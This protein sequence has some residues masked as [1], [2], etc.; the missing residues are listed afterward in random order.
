MSAIPTL[1]PVTVELK[2]SNGVP[3]LSGLMCEL[4]QVGNSRVTESGSQLQLTVAAR[5]EATARRRAEEATQGIVVEVGEPSLLKQFADKGA[6]PYRRSLVFGRKKPG[7]FNQQGG[8]G[9]HAVAAQ[10]Q[11]PT[12]ED[13]AALING[14]TSL[15][16]REKMTESFETWLSALDKILGRIV[17][18]SYLDLPDQN[19]YGWWSD[20]LSPKKA[21]LRAI[22]L[23]KQ[24]QEGQDVPPMLHDNPK[25][26]N[27]RQQQVAVKWFAKKTLRELRRRQ[28]LV[29]AQTK[30]AFS[31]GNTDALQNLNMMDAILRAA[32]DYKEFGESRSTPMKENTSVKGF[33]PEEETDTNLDSLLKNYPIAKDTHETLQKV[34]PNWFA[35]ERGRRTVVDAI[36]QVRIREGHEPADA[37]ESRY[38]HAPVQKIQGD[39]FPVTAPPN[40]TSIHEVRI[41]FLRERDRDFAVRNIHTFTEDCDCAEP[42]GET[43]AV[44]KVCGCQKEAVEESLAS[45]FFGKMNLRAT[46]VQKVV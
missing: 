27:D 39:P 26:Y 14:E 32:I 17:G 5:D 22:K 16:E 24:V 3:M 9:G 23:S 2:E 13:V 19:Y 35:T 12:A 11:T 40:P 31:Q 28:D 8:D 42:H 37:L 33:T 20:G 18:L 7:R 43:E 1:Y 34:P 41:R 10:P 6:L 25:D 38:L 21:A 44:F 45:I 46:E 15:T 36:R 29:Q 30:R 4:I